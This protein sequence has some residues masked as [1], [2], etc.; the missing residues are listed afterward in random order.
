MIQYALCFDRCRNHEISVSLSFTAQIENPHLIM[1]AWIPGS[2]MIRDFA[3]N[4][5]QIEVTTG[6]HK[7]LK[8]G[9]D[10]WQLAG[11]AIGDEVE[12]TYTVYAFDLSVRA[13]YV[14]LDRAFL[15]GTSVFLR[16]SGCSNDSIKVVLNHQPEYEGLSVRTTLPAESIDAQG[17][18]TYATDSYQQA[19]DHP[20]E[21]SRSR[22]TEFV[23][24]N[25]PHKMVFTDA[26]GADIERIARLVAPV[27]AEHASMFGELPVKQYLF[28]TLATADGYGGLEHCDS[29][30]LICRRSDLPFRGDQPLS[31]ANRTY[32]ALCS[33]EYFHLWNVKRIA[34]RQ[35]VESR[36]DVEAY[37]ELLWWFEGA[38]SYYDELALPRCGVISAT[39]YGEMLAHAITRYLRNPGRRRQ[40]IA[41][42]SFDAWTKFY[43]QDENAPNSIV[44]YYNKGALVVFGLDHWIRTQSN[45]QY[46]LDDLT[47]MLWQRHGKVQKP[48]DE[49]SIERLVEE[50]VGISPKE[51][52]ADFVYGTR[53]LPLEEWLGDFGLAMNCRPARGADD[54]GGMSQASDQLTSSPAQLNLGART[55]DD[56]GLLRIEQ[57][58]NDSVAERAGLAPGDI[59]VALAD[60]RVQ[61]GNLSSVI[62]RYTVGDQT[63]IAF[64]RRGLLQ[65][66]VLVWNASDCDTADLCWIP[67]EELDETVLAR[68]QS[69][70]SSSQSSS[71]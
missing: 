43:K 70:L 36:F 21:I 64:F 58:L 7:L 27:C 60:E 61:S 48:V 29:T 16:V 5:T 33:H 59:I 63:P 2:Y 20:I 67:D 10:S 28:L 6:G 32:L 68:R 26:R 56:Q 35:M 54:K 24:D 52:F 53:D 12:V 44:S 38:T 46:S 55:K 71:V 45:D 37:T 30:S 23:V 4:V 19:I 62:A 9:K 66:A 11:V 51:F 40:S 57:V 50:L 49:R 25:I 41:E 14:D 17:F 18:G 69:W 39:D 3:R 31:L 42:S 13:A 8:N 15:N 1:P 34:P 65:E 22:A 47:R